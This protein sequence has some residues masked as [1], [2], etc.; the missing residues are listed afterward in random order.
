M[1]P[2]LPAISRGQNLRII[3]RFILVV[4]V[5]GES[6]HADQAVLARITGK[7]PALQGVIEGGCLHLLQAATPAFFSTAVH[8]SDQQGLFIKGEIKGMQAIDFKHVGS[9]QDGRQIISN[10]SLSS[11]SKR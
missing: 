1:A 8:G 9:L 4:I 6:A 2:T 11:G 10:N 3:I 5:A 7:G